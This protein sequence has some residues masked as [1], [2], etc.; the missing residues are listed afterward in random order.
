MQS[1]ELGPGLRRGTD[2]AKRHGLVVPPRLG[3]GAG[4]LAPLLAA[5]LAASAC[6]AGQG[7]AADV[8][9]CRP[10]S[11]NWRSEATEDD[12]RRLRDW[13][14]A[15]ET[16]TEHARTTAAAEIDAA[17]P[18]LQ[19]DA[20]LRDP[21]PP[22]GDYDCRTLKLG[23]P[24]DSGLPYVAYPTFRCR[25]RIDG[26][27]ISF[28]KLDGSQRP[29]GRLYP[30]SER[31]LIFLGTLQLGDEV[32]AFRY[33]TDSERDLAGILERVGERRWRLALPYPHFESLLDVIELTP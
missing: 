20:A 22:P 16:A 8:Q 7:L 14:R 1:P 5:S 33:G 9:A 32:R 11:E 21:M 4:M 31:R 28:V 29:V 23:S 18:L 19:T 3:L 6:V 13:R 12:R 25:I 17:G 26:E 27:R 2:A 10:L 15:W 24:T 30:D